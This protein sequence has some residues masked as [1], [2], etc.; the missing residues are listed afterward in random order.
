MGDKTK[1]PAEK[2]RGKKL[3][4]NKE[5]IQELTDEQLNEVA[6]GIENSI[7]I[8]KTGTVPVPLSRREFDP[9]TNPIPC[10]V[11]N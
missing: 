9:Y 4:L 11:G 7:G 3:E 5:T 10:P 8:C 1:K 2:K 6:G